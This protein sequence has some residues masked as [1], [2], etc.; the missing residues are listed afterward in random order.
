MGLAVYISA[1]GLDRLAI[2]ASAPCRNVYIDASSGRTRRYCS[3]RCAGRAE[4][5]TGVLAGPDLQ[6][7]PSRTEGRGQ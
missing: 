3:D 4:A 6:A 1:K 7:G 5:D 2:C